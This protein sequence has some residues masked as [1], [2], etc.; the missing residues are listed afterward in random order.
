MTEQGKKKLA[1]QLQK[2]YEA[3]DEMDRD[4]SKIWEL[5]DEA[6]IRAEDTCRRQAWI[7]TIAAGNIC[8]QFDITTDDLHEAEK[9][10][11]QEEEE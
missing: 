10:L 4:A 1:K 6:K 2:I 8:E 3:I 5:L 11:K 7:A 9:E